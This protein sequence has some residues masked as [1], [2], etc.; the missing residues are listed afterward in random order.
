MLGRLKAMEERWSGLMGS[1]ALEPID[2]RSSE[3]L[4]REAGELLARLGR[5][6]ECSEELFADKA[7]LCDFKGGKGVN[8]HPV[9]P[10]KEEKSF[11][12]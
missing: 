1:V 6:L 7:L 5:N 8:E 12:N 9:L 4:Q 3:H 10:A 2:R 11:L